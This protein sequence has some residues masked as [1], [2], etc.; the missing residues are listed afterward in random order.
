M[1]ARMP[2][3]TPRVIGRAIEGRILEL[4]DVTSHCEVIDTAK[5]SGET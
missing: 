2:S 5:L 4:E 3:T 1:I